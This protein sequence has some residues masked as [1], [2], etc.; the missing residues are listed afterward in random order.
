MEQCGV[1]AE[2]YH[3]SSAAKGTV[4]VTDW[5]CASNNPKG[6]IWSARA[7]ESRLQMTAPPPEHFT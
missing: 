2:V 5:F 7:P 3:S 6:L 1:R 4:T